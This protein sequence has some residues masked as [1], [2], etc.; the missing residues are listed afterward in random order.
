MDVRQFT[1]MLYRLEPDRAVVSTASPAA[2]QGTRRTCAKLHQMCSVLQVES[3]GEVRLPS[4]PAVFIVA[5][6]YGLP[7]VSQA[8]ELWESGLAAEG[9]SLD[10]WQ[11]SGKDIPRLLGEACCRLRP[12][13]PSI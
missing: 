1:S 6:A 9:N 8:V 4:Q 10:V 3:V 5:T 2:S 12:L 11:W 13:S 7:W